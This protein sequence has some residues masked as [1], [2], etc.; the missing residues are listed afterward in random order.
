MWGIGF[1]KQIAHEIY[2]SGS[3]SDCEV[4]SGYICMALFLLV[5]DFNLSSGARR[6]EIGDKGTAFT[7][8]TSALFGMWCFGFC[9]FSN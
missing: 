7:A 2:S 9:A 1:L 5:L 3:L 8:A 6:G 4:G